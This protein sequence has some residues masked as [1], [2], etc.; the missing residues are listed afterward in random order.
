MAL[1]TLVAFPVAAS[2][3]GV[4]PDIV[5]GDVSIHP[6]DAQL[7]VGDTIEV[8]G[9]WDASTANP[10]PGDVFTIGLPDVFAFAEP[11]PFALLGGDG[12]E[13]G[14]CL[15]D[16]DTAVATC[17]LSDAVLERP[18]EVKGEWEFELSVVQAT[19]AETV[20]FDLNG[21]PTVVDLPGEG[22]IDDGIDLPGEVSKSGVMNANNWSMTWTI[23]IPGA[24]MAGQSSVTVHDALGEGHELCDPTELTVQTVRGSAVV[25]V[26]DLVTTAPA[27]GATEFDIVLTAPA[28][29]FRDDVIYRVTYETCTPGER[30][31]PEGTTYVNE[32]QVEGWG[33]AGVGI[34]TVTNRPWLTDLSKS[35]S[36][37]GG[38]DRNAV[39]AWTVSIP[40][41][42]LDGDSGFTLSDTLGEGHELCTDTISGIRVVERYGPSSEDQRN[43]TSLLEATTLSSSEQ[44]FEVRFD[45]DDPGFAF[46]GGDHRYIVTYE[47]CVTSEEL[48]DGGT[49]YANTVEVDGETAGAEAKVPGRSQGKSGSIN[50]AVVTIDG[51]EYMP[52]TTLDWSIRI[53]GERI[54]G[55]VGELTLSDTLSETQTVC[56]AGE[57]SEGLASR[58]DLSVRAIDQISG[59]GL[60]TVDLTDVTEVAVEGDEITFDIAATDLPTP[61]GGE[62]DGFSREYQYVLEYTT[63]TTSGGMDAPG[64][65]YDNDVVGS[66]IAFRNSIS[67]ENSAGGTGQGVTRGSVSI[68]KVLADTP[69]AAFVPDDATFTVHVAEIDPTGTTQ[70]EYDLSVPVNGDPVSGFNARGTGWTVELTEPTFPE[71]P[72]VTFGTPSFA[73]APGVSVSDDGTV[74]TAEITPGANVA[75]TLENEALLGSMHVVKELTGAAASEVDPDREYEMT[76][77]ID[78]SALGDTVPEQDDRTFDLKAGEEK[79]L[80]DLPIGSVVT[81]TEVRPTDDDRFTWAAP[82]VS[83]E[84]VEITAAHATDPAVVTVTNT[85]ERTV[86]TFS[87][88]KSITGEQAANDAVPDSVTVEASWSEEGSPGS[89]TLTVPTDGTPVPLGEDLLIG[90]EVTLAEAPLEDG[91]SI[92]WGAPVWSGDGVRVEGESA[93][94][95]VGRDDDA[96]VT[97]ENHAATSTAGI[98]ILKGIAGEAEGE[99]DPSTEFPVTA[100]WTDASGDLQTREVSINAVDPT[101]LGVDLPAGTVITLTEGQAPAID[102]V[103]WGDV[104]ISGDE[105]TDG[106]DGSATVV[107]SDQQ[108]EVTL[109][110]VV[111]EATWAPGTFSVAKSVTGVPLTDPDVPD[112]VAVVATWFQ[113]GDEHTTSFEVPVDGTVVEF[114]QALPHGTEVTL[115]EQAP[116]DSARFT[117]ATPTW[118]GD[119]VTDGS[120]SAVVTIGAA[121]VAEVDLEN[122]VLASLGTLTLTK[123]VTGDGADAASNVTFPVTLSWT[124]LFGDS[125]SRDVEIRAGESVAID[126]LPIGV[127]VTVE[128]HDAALP[129][130]VRWDAATWAAE[131]D[132]VTVSTDSGS[133]VAVVMITGDPGTAVEVSLENEIGE[134]PDLALTGAGA[135]SGLVIGAALFL[136]VAGLLLRRRRSAI[137]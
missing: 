93:V 48:P 63:C 76:V 75:V 38:D 11:V 110:S 133:A 7:T 127:E 18:E 135:V 56:A 107:V 67:Q 122:T 40:G 33:D 102:T 27:P 60:A 112:A 50:T 80:E 51:V 115:V 116:Q 113:N 49:V 43:I 97:L 86:G 73:S 47:T 87:V 5:V 6:D 125:Q 37:R 29:G 62:S 71:I 46:E 61:D 3:A 82:V 123:S 94:V 96:T 137:E 99:V 114:P 42:Q 90:T 68:E 109:V 39:I 85:V 16:P 98:S 12:T 126:D 100:T 111:N 89:A 45:I 55:I 92:A 72:G 2:A 17:T 57:S 10:Q 84:S 95:T 117:W 74:A 9:T 79:T 77:S 105:V 4:N 23:D 65:V 121:T 81:V 59:G 19:T 64:T 26:T 31:D 120:G 36:V 30:I 54:E 66:G 53:P 130:G 83:P 24:N 32:A 78:T 70:A 13:W 52:Q 1:V 28:E 128:E 118:S 58:L 20:T 91:A 35:G 101:P 44:A 8:S 103:V 119:V 22:G 136:I 14:S 88:V 132:D 69:G 41:E 25:D 129:S 104:V 108:G 131:S 134:V 34:G 21:T 15:T 124:D 106:G